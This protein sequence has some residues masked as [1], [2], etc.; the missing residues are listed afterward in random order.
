M[1]SLKKSKNTV[2]NFCNFITVRTIYL[3]L[4]QMF[5]NV[6]SGK[7][8]TNAWQ[9][10]GRNCFLQFLFSESVQEGGGEPKN[11]TTW[12]MDAHLPDQNEDH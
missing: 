9:I 10:F 4:F 6:N 8:S 7:N 11:L 3:S 12:F 5:L 1:H 2:T